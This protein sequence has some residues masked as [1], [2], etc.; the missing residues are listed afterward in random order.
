MGQCRSLRPQDSGP[1]WDSP[2]HIPYPRRG[3]RRTRRRCP[4]HLLRSKDAALLRKITVAFR[5]VDDASEDR[6][7]HAYLCRFPA[8]SFP[9]TT[10]TLGKP[11]PF[12]EA[13]QW[14]EAP[15]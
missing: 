12:E 15:H 6:V 11:P 5:P 1:R 14:T 7:G 8:E 3:E 13:R 2:I 9:E 4:E 10:S